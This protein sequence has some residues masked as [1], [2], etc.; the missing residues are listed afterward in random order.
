MYSIP[1]KR[2]FQPLSHKLL[3][4]GRL[5]AALIGIAIAVFFFFPPV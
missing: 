2:D 5:V 1:Q 3:D 4:V